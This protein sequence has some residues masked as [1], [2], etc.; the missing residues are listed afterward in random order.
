M[1]KENSP[2]IRIKDE[3][4]GFPTMTS[5]LNFH[6][7]SPPHSFPFLISLILNIGPG[8]GEKIIINSYKGSGR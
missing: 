1:E 3:L 4:S 8:R 2:T 7:I 6:K 5:Y